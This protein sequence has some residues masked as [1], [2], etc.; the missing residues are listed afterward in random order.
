M[1]CVYNEK[2][3]LNR[4]I[5]SKNKITSIVGSYCEKENLTDCINGYWYTR[6]S[7]KFSD[8]NYY[9][10]D[11]TMSYQTNCEND[12]ETNQ[13]GKKLVNRI[14]YFVILIMLTSVGLW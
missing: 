11:E 3:L 6:L 2:F 9:S 12:K 13:V 1:H 14:H 5:I 7:N 8:Y 4:W 10:I